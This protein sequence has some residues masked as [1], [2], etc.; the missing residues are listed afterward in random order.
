MTDPLILQH[1]FTQIY[2]KQIWNMGQD[3]SKSGLGSTLEYT[4]SIRENL[5]D[6][7]K[8]NNI[9]NMIDT[10]CGDWNWMKLIQDQ[11]CDYTGIDIV[12][13]VIDINKKK[14][15]N[16]KTRFACMDILSYLKIL[17]SAS[18]DLILCR[19]TCEHLP[20]DYVLELLQEYKRVSKYLLLTTKKTSE[21]EICNQDLNVTQMSYRPINLDKPPFDALLKEYFLCELYDGPFSNRDPQ[22]YIYAYQFR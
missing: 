13:D 12:Q 1:M 18:V 14:Y 7:I 5:I 20:L 19:H 8:K 2:S 15:E 6:F 9:K 3:E 11:L 10:S 17:P 21:S 4:K 16:E 22:M